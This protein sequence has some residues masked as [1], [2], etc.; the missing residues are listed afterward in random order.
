MGTHSLFAGLVWAFH[1]CP[2]GAVRPGIVRSMTSGQVLIAEC[3]AHLLETMR[4]LPE[5][6]PDG[7]G[8]GNKALEEAAGYALALE[9][10]D[11]WFT[12]SLLAALAIEGK[13]EVLQPGKRDKKYRLA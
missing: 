7:D 11:G 6:S 10:N 1:S 9:R 4:A 2:L 5:C 13:V 3:K 8:L 12:W